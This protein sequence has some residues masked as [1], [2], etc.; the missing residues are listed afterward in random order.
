MDDRL[1]DWNSLDVVN[2]P[3]RG[4]AKEIIFRCRLSCRASITLL[5]SIEENSLKF[6]VTTRTATY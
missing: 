2:C 5:N 3:K 1:R 6:R 4:S